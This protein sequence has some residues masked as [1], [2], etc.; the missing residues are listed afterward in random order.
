[1]DFDNVK[2][3][4]YRTLNRKLT[5]QSQCLDKEK[6]SQGSP[7][8]PSKPSCAQSWKEWLL[9]VCAEIDIQSYF[10]GDHL[11]LLN[12]GKMEPW[13]ESRDD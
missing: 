9:R 1:M 2:R 6:T 12:Q 4:R 5:H 7:G 8:L 10:K 13:F 3:N 11:L